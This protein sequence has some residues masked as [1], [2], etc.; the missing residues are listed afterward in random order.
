V[1]LQKEIRRTSPDYVLY[2]PESIA[3]TGR[4]SN[5]HILVFDGPDGN[6][7]AVWTQSTLEKATDL[8]IAFAKSGDGGR[9][10]SAPMTIAGPGGGKG[11]A[12]WGF[13]MVSKSGRIYVLHNRHIGVN[14]MF[15][16]TTGLMEGTYSDDG[17]TTW[18][19]GQTIARPRT[20]WD[21]PDPAIPGNWIVWQRP[22][23]LSNGKYYVGYT[24]W[25]SPSAPR[26]GPWKIS[27]VV[28][29]MRFE[30]LDDDPEPADLKISWHA[31]D[32]KALQLD[33]LGH[34]GV[35]VIQEPSIVTLPDGRLFCVCRTGTGNPWY[36]ISDDVG[37]TWSEPCVLRQSDHH[38]P[39]RNPVSPCPLYRVGEKE[40]VFFFHNHDGRF[41][42]WGPSD[43]V[44]IRRPIWMCRALFRPNAKQ[45]L[46]F[47]EPRFFYDD[48]GVRILQTNAMYSSLSIGS[49]GTIVWYPD[50]KFF[51]L[52][53]KIA[54]DVLDEMIVPE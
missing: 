38:L 28:E 30:N 21:N 6:L 32:E 1:D 46:S 43:T 24:H 36:V 2:A 19:E 39:L 33:V 29:F 25:V 13:P 45:P 31:H 18:S 7:C 8:H 11:M 5:Q 20:R 52:G 50:R 15:T 48:D 23:R 47:S 16:H 22:N 3:S 53:R 12:C 49:E 17:G 42:G 51:L 37:D 27:S 4:T 14:D 41:G 26:Q 40:Y 54:R 10:W 35:P 44:Y 9:T 34:S